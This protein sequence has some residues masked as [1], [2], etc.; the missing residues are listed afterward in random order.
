MPKVGGTKAFVVE[1]VEVPRKDFFCVI[2]QPRPHISEPPGDP[3]WAVE[4]PTRKPNTN[5]NFIMKTSEIN[6][7]LKC[8]GEGGKNKAQLLFRPVKNN[9]RQILDTLMSDEYDSPLWRT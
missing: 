7:L 1:R 9:A 6:V 4:T 8:K 5:S 2:C 3:A